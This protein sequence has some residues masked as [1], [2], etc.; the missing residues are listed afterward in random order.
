VNPEDDTRSFW[1]FTSPCGC[2]TGV[3]TNH[4]YGRVRAFRVMFDGIK[5][6][7]TA[8]DDGVTARLVDAATYHRE[9]HSLIR[10]DHTCQAASGSV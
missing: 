8:I 3:L 5:P 2:T 6:A 1:V 9:I 10:A 4:G 7:N